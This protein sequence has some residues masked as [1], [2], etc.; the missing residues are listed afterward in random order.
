MERASRDPVLRRRRVAGLAVAACGAAML[1]FGLLQAS[2]VV[3]T[4][5][6]R[7]DRTN[8]VLGVEI[9][10]EPTTSAGPQADPALPAAL[11]GPS[12]AVAPG[13]SVALGPAETQRP[14]SSSITARPS[15]TTAPSPSTTVGICGGCGDLWTRSPGPNQPIQLTVTSPSDLHVGDEFVVSVR[16]ADPDALLRPPFICV[17]SDDGSFTVGFHG[18]DAPQ[19][20]CLLPE[21]CVE[22]QP[23]RSDPPAPTGSEGTWSVRLS[24]TRVGSYTISVDIDSQTKPC[25]PDPYA[26]SAHDVRGI[27]VA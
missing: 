23:A 18:D 15:S 20:V 7:A 26:S 2:R 24:L 12:A 22:Q 19:D 16:A 8:E 6:Q 9:H 4:T 5:D 21:Q 13:S 17:Q 3:T 11:G 10:R 1:G 14:R 25:G 27:E